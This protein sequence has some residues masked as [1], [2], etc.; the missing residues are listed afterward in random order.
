MPS[1]SRDIPTSMAGTGPAVATGT[2]G[3]SV[4]VITTVPPRTL[5]GAEMSRL[6][7]DGTSRPRRG[8]LGASLLAVGLVA[9]LLWGPQLIRRNTHG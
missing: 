2:A 9:A 3:A 5:N 4:I 8:I 6:P 7:A 1:G